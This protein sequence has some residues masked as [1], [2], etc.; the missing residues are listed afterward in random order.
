MYSD[1]ELNAPCLLK[2]VNNSEF[3]KIYPFLGN[4]KQVYELIQKVDIAKIG[5]MLK[6]LNSEDYEIGISAFE[7]TESNEEAERF[8]KHRI[9]EVDVDVFKK[10]DGYYKLKCALEN[11]IFPRNTA[12]LIKSRF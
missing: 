7:E 6:D 5:D 9:R 10:N 3:L 8:N 4:K 12:Y 11:N 2:R 1:L